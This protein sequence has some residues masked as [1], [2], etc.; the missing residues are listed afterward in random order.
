VR[1][2]FIGTKKDYDLPGTLIPD[3][4]L[5]CVTLELADRTPLYLKGRGDGE[6][7]ETTEAS[8]IDSESFES[9]DLDEVEPFANVIGTRL[10][11]LTLL[12]TRGHVRHAGIRLQFDTGEL[13]FLNLWD[14]IEVYDGL[15]PE[16]LQPEDV[17]GRPYIHVYEYP[18]VGTG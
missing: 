13:V 16:V 8:Y 2:T 5:I 11:E 9:R 3:L 4:E 7:L 6:G 1:G 14:E 17:P 18:Y 15:V 12:S 10:R